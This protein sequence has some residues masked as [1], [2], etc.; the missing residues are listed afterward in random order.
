MKQDPGACGGREQQCEP[1]HADT[2]GC[3]TGT[4]GHNRGRGYLSR[5]VGAD[6]LD[7]LHGLRVRLGDVVVV[8]RPV[9][10][11]EGP[12]LGH[13]VAGRLGR[14]D[15]SRSMKTGCPVARLRNRCRAHFG[16]STARGSR[17]A[18]AGMSIATLRR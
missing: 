13:V 5:L 11:A 3:G 15:P 2:E 10:V 16:G 4:A 9:A 1:E 17:A 6:A 8:H 18:L 7:R 12:L 14:G